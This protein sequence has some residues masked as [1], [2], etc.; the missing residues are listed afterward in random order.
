[1]LFALELFLV[2]ELAAGSKDAV[3]GF[4][5]RGIGPGRLGGDD[6]AAAG[7]STGDAFR[8][9]G[10]LH[11][12]DEPFQVALLLGLEIAGLA[13]GEELEVRLVHSAGTRVGAASGAGAAV[14][15]L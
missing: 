5:R 9:L 7:S 2:G 15:G 10:D 12:G 8:R 1:M 4:E 6:P 3:L 13:R 14:R 11:A